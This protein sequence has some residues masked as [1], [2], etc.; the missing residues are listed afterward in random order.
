MP[1]QSS[2]VANQTR[3]RQTECIAV[4]MVHDLKEQTKKTATSV[5]SWRTVLPGLTFIGYNCMVRCLPF[6]HQLQVS[7]S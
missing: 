6:M 1:R 5:N 3:K 2:I 4:L 7:N